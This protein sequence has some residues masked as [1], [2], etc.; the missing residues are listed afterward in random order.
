MLEAQRHEAAPQ[1]KPAP[2]AGATLVID[3]DANGR[4]AGTCAG[5]AILL[6]RL[7]S[8]GRPRPREDIGGYFRPEYRQ[9][10]QEAWQ[11]CAATGNVVVR[12]LAGGAGNDDFLLELRVAPRWS[13]GKPEPESYV[14]VIRDVGAESR[15]GVALARLAQVA[16]HTSNLVIITDAERRIE[17]VNEAF[18]RASGYTLGEAR[19]RRPG[20]LLQFEGTDPA[21]VERIRAEL[22]AR[23]PVHA[24]ILNR[25]KSGRQYWL[26]LDIHPVMTGAGSLD[27]FVAVQTDITEKRLQ[28]QQLRQLAR[29]ACTARSMLQAAVEALPDGFAM[30]SAE[31]RLLLHNRAYRDLHP[32][33]ADL[34]PGVTLSDML[35]GELARGEYPQVKGDEEAWMAER[36]RLLREDRGWTAELEL[37]DG[38]WVRSVKLAAAQG[39]F[40]ALRSDITHLKRAEQQAVWHRV[41][42][43]DAL[44]DPMAMSDP[45]GRLTYVNA[46]FV[47]A[48]GGRSAKDWVG[49]DWWQIVPIADSEAVAHAAEKSLALTGCWRGYLKAG[50]A[51]ATGWSTQEASLTRAPDGAL[52]LITRDVGD[53]EKS[54]ESETSL[55]DLLMSISSRYLNTSLEHVDSAIVQ[56]LGQI[57]RYVDADRAYL[58]EY[59]WIANTTSNTHEWCAP[60]VPTQRD[61]LQG[62]PL[63]LLG[64]WVSTHRAGRS[65][66]IP[67]VADLPADAPLRRILE[68]QGI[69]SLIAIPL[70]GNEGC[71]G[72]VGFDSVRREHSHT[73]REK[74]LLEFFCEISR[75]LRSRTKLELF[76]LE[77]AE[78]LRREEQRAHIQEAIVQEQ[79]W[80]EARLAGALLEMQRLHERDQQMRQASEMLVS[81]LRSLSETKDLEEGPRHL[82]AQLSQALETGCVALLPLHGD[83]GLQCLEHPQW[84]HDLLQDR[85]V[86]D[87]LSSRPRRLVG[88]LSAAP[89]YDRLA[90]TWPPARLRWLAAARVEP[91]GYPYLL[92]VAG[93]SPEGLDQG[94]SLLFQRF[95]PVLAE[96]LRRRDDSLRERKLEQELQHAHK[97]EALGALAGGIAHEINTPMQYIS[98]NLHFLRDSFGELLAALH[99]QGGAGPQRAA[100]DADLEFLAREIPLALD[101]SLSGSRRVVEIVEA[102]RTTAYPEL[103]P[104]QKIDMRSTLESCLVITRGSWKHDIDLSLHGD[105]AVPVLRGSPG[106]I[107]QVFVNLITNACD[108]VRAT[109][110]GRRGVVRIILGVDSGDVVVHVDDNGPG[111]PVELRHRIFERYFTTK[112]VGKGTGRGLDICRSIVERHGGEIR[113]D[114][115]PLGGARFT[116]RLPTRTERADRVDIPPPDSGLPLLDLNY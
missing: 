97:L 16:K 10:V 11:E 21:T 3:I 6:H 42:A 7:G 98:D 70:M 77:A 31:G 80:S 17:W 104:D 62:I 68:P 39:G 101:Q 58:F 35:R 96:A 84:W 116:V 72:F 4:L 65:I 60:G 71:E 45:S 73:K 67:R 95:V 92:L 33:A 12:A 79:V 94:R 112:E 93:Q 9:A 20:E 64:D 99:R 26:S 22:G 54:L 14:M 23:R 88:N 111:V 113:L 2:S 100:D 24:E 102:V 107:S 13:D 83:E 105:P 37:A 61:A 27:G 87:H 48:F 40:I 29:E 56:A 110:D 86:I 91:L 108:A 89:I 36:M 28:E 82:L 74:E 19:G 53:L 47:R 44:Q 55:L 51:D 5:D 38:R 57:A 66:N 59:D 76:N 103:A 43:M 15:S 106:Q 46:A 8:T 25:S 18:T 78:K 109:Q 69:K 34:S 50:G 75:S 41:A 63:A 85:A 1:S 90:S 115:S 114:V 49:R 52:V 32:L 81:A 30:F